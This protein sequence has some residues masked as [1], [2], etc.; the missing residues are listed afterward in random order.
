M[1]FRL[2]NAAV[3]DIED[4]YI[5]GIIKW[6]GS[7]AEKYHASLF[8]TFDLLAEMPMIVRLSERKQ[9]EERRFPHGAHI[10]Y[11][12]PIEH[13]VEIIRLLAGRQIIDIW[14]DA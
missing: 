7:Q 10:I 8:R 11:Y 13:G 12:R 14:G 6:G 1:P 9:E 4:I 3:A 2:T 5:E